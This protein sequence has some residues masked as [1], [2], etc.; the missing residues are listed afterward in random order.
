M[1]GFA[2]KFKARLPRYKS[3]TTFAPHP[4]PGME[5]S[6]STTTTLILLDLQVGTSVTYDTY[7]FRST[8][9]F[10]GIKQIPEGLHL[11]T[12]GIDQ[13]ELG[14][15]TGFFFTA[16]PGIV[17]AWKWEETTEQLQ[18]IDEQVKGQDLQERIFNGDVNQTDEIGLLSLHPY[19]TNAPTAEEDEGKTS[20]SE[21]TCYIT[22]A[23]L[24][25]IL[26]ATWAFASYTP[27]TN[28]DTTEQLF[29]LPSSQREEILHF[30][31]IDLKRTFNPHAI[32]GERTSQFL[33]K[34]YYLETLLQQL[35]NELA[36][37][38]EFQLSFLTML[39]MNNF[40]G[41][42]AWKNLFTVF[43]GCKRAL[44]THTSLFKHFLRVLREQFDMC[45][46]ETF[47]EIILESQFVGTNLRMLNTAIEDL[48]PSSSTL[49][50][51]FA[52]LTAL[53]SAKFDW[54]LTSGGSAQRVRGAGGMT[55]LELG[56]DETG[57]DMA[58]ECGDYAPVVVDVGEM[59]DD[60]DVMD[61]DVDFKR[62]WES[63]GTMD[64]KTGKMVFGK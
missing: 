30:T 13:S 51:G 60:G 44:Q 52:Q 56:Y 5:A 55:M 62:R 47:N 59:S 32:G 7:S 20:W 4:P 39:Y 25:R 8:R 6:Y 40:S 26:P 3:S 21:L 14:M 22:P 15:R 46:E 34:T 38:G 12:Y 36:L 1:V 54:D 45:S 18:R 63:A 2:A 53:L 58:R 17:S 37:L 29:N 43:C 42:E 49:E 64:M 27:S 35:P 48:D 41:F 9:S 57:W 50:F 23:L 61:E 19:L 11:L 33:D 16:K 28:D 10:R 24:T 31:S